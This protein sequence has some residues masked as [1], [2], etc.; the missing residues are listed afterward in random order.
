M[1]TIKIELSEIGNTISKVGRKPALTC[2]LSIS[3]LWYRRECPM[4]RHRVQLF[5][6]GCTWQT[7]SLMRSCMPRKNGIPLSLNNPKIIIFWS[8]LSFS[9]SFTY[10][11]NAS[12]FF[13]KSVW[14]TPENN[15]LFFDA[16][17]FRRHKNHMPHFR[18]HNNQ[19]FWALTTTCSRFHQV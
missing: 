15:F 14:T 13:K 3:K 18:R 7:W 4:A 9:A 8:D 6:S 12:F 19:P 5:M 11:W 1:Y 10:A 2:R 17:H 16:V